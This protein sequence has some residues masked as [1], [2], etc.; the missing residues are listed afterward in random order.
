MNLIR[1][2]NLCKSYRN[3]AN[4]LE[5]LRHVEIQIDKGEK[6]AIVGPSG[7]GKSTLLQILGCLDAPTSGN[8]YLDGI[9]VAA[10]NDDQLSQ[11]RGQKIGFVFQAFHLF[12]RMTLAENVALP[13][14][15][16]GVAA[17]ERI[18]RAQAALTQVNLSHRQDHKPHELS[19]GEKQRGA[20]ARAMV[21][22]PPLILADEPTGNLDPSVKSEILDYLSSLNREHNVTIVLVTHDANTAAWAERHIS[23]K[24]GQVIGGIVH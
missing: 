2:E 18:A 20:I 7:S 5:V 16:Q 19:G 10:L 9:D 8:Y 24:E 15:Y 17:E 6:I 23:F 1:C 21:H 22:R 12:P 14:L 4:A 13:L 11:L 3:G